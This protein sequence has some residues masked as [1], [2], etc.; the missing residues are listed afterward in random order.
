MKLRET[1]PIQPEGEEPYDDAEARLAPGSR[2][3]RYEI[4]RFVAEGG[5]GAVYEAD[6][7]EPL[8]RRVALKVLRDSVRANPQVVARF[9]REAQAAAQLSHRACATIFDTG[10]EGGHA[11]L[12]MEFL[13]GEVL[14]E[15]ITREGALPTSFAAD[16]LV[17]VLSAVAAAHDAGIVHRDLKPANIF[18]A[19]QRSGAVRPKLLDFGIAK[20]LGEAAQAD[21][22]VTRTGSFL[23]TPQYASPEQ[24]EQSRAVDG[25][26]DQFALG[27]ILYEC[28]T[29]T[30]PWPDGPA[31]RVLLAVTSGP[32]EPPR[33]R[34]PEVPPELEAV[35]LR[36]LARDPSQRF[37][38]ARAF[39]RALLPFASEACRAEWRADL[40]V[41]APLALRETAPAPAPPVPRT[42]PI[43]VPPRRTEEA[44]VGAL[45]TLLATPPPV[46]SQ[47]LPSPTGGRRV[48]AVA[49]AVVCAL[50][51]LVALRLRA[52]PQQASATTPPRVQ[53]AALLPPAAPE[54]YAVRVRATPEDA[55]FELDDGAA[56]AGPL[57][58]TLP[59]D[60]RAHA[61][62]VS[63]PGYVAVV[64]TFRDAPPP[65]RVT[66]TAVA[67][68]P[69][70]S[71]PTVPTRTHGH[72]HR[73]NGSPAR[74]AGGTGGIPNV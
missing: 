9:L 34:N 57:V 23:G 20:L 54:T 47:P 73:R 51:V 7:V 15:R 38:D 52:A 55:R 59:R 41:E 66:L 60:G 40:E 12:A 50:A 46:Q 53:T 39:G 31:F 61:L 2:F 44:A 26:S 4:R 8:R 33:A 11:W 24:A 64:L 49:A 58:R 18:L 16:V 37:A 14:E 63:A 72:P 45:P 48:V 13:E 70:P 71:P 43:S 17:P 32:I 28:L 30:R 19:R 62:R 67:P 74:D 1:P 3:G 56:A 69:P 42:A 10:A 5:F 35:V 6:Q 68:E 36:A 65:E 21:G 22:A 25:R 29:G 27:V